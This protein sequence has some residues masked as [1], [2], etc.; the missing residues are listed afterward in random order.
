M[1]TFPAGTV[2]GTVSNTAGSTISNTENANPNTATLAIKSKRRRVNTGPTDAPAND[3]NASNAS[4]PI[5]KK[6]I[7]A[8][9][10]ADNSRALRK[11][12][13]ILDKGS[14]GSR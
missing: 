11:V 13:V 6:P 4:E 8:T 5:S 1:S 12:Q 9:S 14:L 7:P 2:G 3:S 10:A